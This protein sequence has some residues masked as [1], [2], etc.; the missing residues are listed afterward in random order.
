M[1][2]IV[3]NFIICIYI[4]PLVVSVI[5]LNLSC[6]IPGLVLS[7]FD[8][9]EHQTLRDTYILLAYRNSHTQS[10]GVNAMM[11]SD[12]TVT[13]FVPEQN[14]QPNYPVDCNFWATP[15]NCLS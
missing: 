8:T 13:I 1:D 4:Q 14:L 6:V 5:I 2:T 11:Q 10:V 3:N 7:T 9:F 12:C 15:N